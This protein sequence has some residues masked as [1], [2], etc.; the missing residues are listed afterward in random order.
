MIHIEKNYNF[1][2]FWNSKDVKNSIYSWDKT[3]KFNNEVKLLK[4]IAF[5]KCIMHNNIM[6]LKYIC[7]C[8]FC[9]DIIYHHV[10]GVYM[11]KVLEIVCENVRVQSSHWTFQR[12]ELHD[13]K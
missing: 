13:W 3:I 4:S 1:F 11:V 12:C 5:W 8:M 6:H 10:N 7:V 9:N 2:S